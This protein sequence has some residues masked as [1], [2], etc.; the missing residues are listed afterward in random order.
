VAEDG[1]GRDLSSLTEHSLRHT[2]APRGC[3]LYE[4]VA[5]NGPC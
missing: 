2:G 4:S 5:T 1:F 3:A